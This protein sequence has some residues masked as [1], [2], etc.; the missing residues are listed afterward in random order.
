MIIVGENKI[1][2]VIGETASGKDYLV[3]RFLKENPNFSKVVAYTSRPTREGEINHVDYHFVTKEHMLEMIDSGDIIEYSS[4]DVVIENGKKDT[5]YYGTHKLSFSD[6]EKNYIC[7]LDNSGYKYIKK[8]Y[9]DK[10]VGF[11]I[12]LDDE[13]RRKNYLSRGGIIEEYERRVKEDKKKFEEAKRDYG[14]FHIVNDYDRTEDIIKM[15]ND[16]IKGWHIRFKVI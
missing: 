15:M 3:N 7:I 1:V 13:I 6:S 12:H 2:I 5:W 16:I 8:V 10:V 9:K 11:M 4:Y 14:L